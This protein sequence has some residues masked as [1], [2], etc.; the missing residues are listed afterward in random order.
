MRSSILHSLLLMA[1]SI[2]APQ[3]F[4]QFSD[5]FNDGDYINNPTWTGTTDN[6]IVNVTSELQLND[7]APVI[8]QSSLQTEN[9][10]SSLAD[11]EWR[12]RVKQTFSGSDANQSRI[13]IVAN[14]PVTGY[15]GN[16][17]AGVQGYFMKLGEG[18]S[19]DVV[20]FYKDD[21][22]T[23]T[24]LGSCTTLIANSFNIQ[25]K[26]LRGASGDWSIGIDPTAGENFVEEATFT[27]NTYN[28]SAYYGIVCTY[29]S[30]N[31][32]K[33]FFD[34]IYVGNPI[35]DLDPP[36]LV[37]ALATSENTVDVLFNEPVQLS[38][39]QQTSNYT[40]SGFSS[41]NSATR[42]AS[43][44]A[45]VHLVFGSSFTLNQQYTLSVNN[46]ADIAGNAMTAPGSTTFQW[47]SVAAP[48]FRDV[49]FSEILADPTPVVGLPDA[50]FVELY[51]SHAVNTFDLSGWV[52]VNTTTEK[53]LPSYI[54]PPGGY[55]I[56]CD[57]NNVALFQE[58]GPVIGISSFTALTNAT[59]SLTLK[60]SDGQIIDVV[61]YSDAWFA[62]SVKRE[63]GWSLELINPTIP[64][65][66]SVNWSESND[67][68]GGTPDAVNSV[69]NLTPD[70]TAPVALSVTVLSPTQLFVQFSEPVDTT[71][72]SNPFWNI[73]PFNSTNGALW[74]TTLSAVT[75][76]TQSPLSPPNTYQLIVNG[77]SDCSGNMMVNTTLSFTLGFAPQ[78]GEL[79]INELMPDPDP[80]IG[81]PSGEYV[82]I[83]NNSS[84]LID[85]S[86]VQLNSGEF[87]SQVF[88]QPNGFLIVIDDS[89]I[90]AFAGIPN[91]A[92]MPSFPGLTNSGLTLE[93]KTS[94]DVQL[95]II[96]Y[97]LTWYQDNTKSDGGWSL[98]RI[99]PFAPCS[100]KF[101]WRASISNTG[102]T[103]GAENSVFSTEPTASPFVLNSGFL[104][105]EQLYIRFSKSMDVNTVA[106]MNPSLQP[107]NS[108][109]N[110]VWNIDKD[111]VTFS[112]ASSAITET[113]YQL[114]IT[115]L[116]DCEGDQATPELL[117]FV[118]GIQPEFGDIII[119][120][121]LADGT[122]TDQTASP[123]FDFI[124][125]FNRTSTIIELT[126]VTVNTGY[127]DRQVILYPDSFIVVTNAANDPAAFSAFPNT[128]YMVSFPSLTEDG[129]A[130]TLSNP[131]GVLDR[132]TYNKNF[133]QDP[134]KEDGGWSMELINPLDPCSAADNWSGCL[135]PSGTTAGRRNSVHNISP[136]T[137]APVLQYILGEPFLAITLVFNEPLDLESISGLSWIVNGEEIADFNPIL[138]GTENN[139]LI[140][141]YGAMTPGVTYGFELFGITDCWDNVASIITGKFGY[142]Q[143]PQEGDLI[144]NEILYNPKDNGYDFIE[145]YNRSPRIL[146]LSQWK[147]ADATNTIMNTPK[148][149]FDVNYL[150][151]PGEILAITKESS[152]MASIYPGT[153]VE[154]LWELKTL[155]DY[156]SI[157][158]VF[159]VMPTGEI[160]DHIAYDEDMQYPLLNSFDGVS[161]ERI[162]YTRPTS[163]RT[164][165]HSASEKVNFAT[166][167]YLNSQSEL[168]MGN[169]EV[170]SI[171]PEIFSPDNDGNNDVVT[172]HYKM[173]EAGF[174]GDIRIYDSEGRFVRHLMK[175]E[176]LGAT[177]SISWDGFTEDRQKASIGIYVIFFEAFTTTGNTVKAKK[178]CV[179]A[180]TLR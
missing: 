130:I 48:S 90:D 15:T 108:V 131:A 147:L 82:E 77:L 53:I 100:G 91:V 122:T 14:G 135:S 105:E 137:K 133:Y 12:I 6:F 71:D 111:L 107:F 20:R 56:L 25:I 24:L 88:I 97:D 44:F 79:I 126:E 65:Q 37:S 143:A 168:S 99:N 129:M 45:L 104:S 3:I 166:P 26:V 121:I 51:N 22:V 80:V 38:S 102:G 165:W 5:D 17:S 74:S 171:A 7:I 52:F 84:N 62:S 50:E 21:G 173:N 67:P 98:E 118:I 76:T 54:L 163:D 32:T 101:N 70:T 155:P 92:V 75:L 41:P 106:D 145:I 66:S 113:F 136:D 72:F 120:E 83:R 59:D 55:V 85:V 63:G 86:S 154:R 159:L 10:M 141:S 49:L 139:M 180:S 150:L 149:L 36:Q 167:G 39:S 23:T 94:D 132:V 68:N 1:F 58:Y 57:A 29:T 31:A 134:G 4:A 146:S 119:N 69:F 124:E 148:L 35:V 157:D 11:K 161:L 40:V 160:S 60:Y 61:V 179:L 156:S 127:F 27:D 73:L 142:A 140:M 177:G 46:I 174:T 151:L 128:A 114:D 158:E 43:N 115:G 93:M 9:A 18:L 123:K 2:F 152:T 8:T 34:D 112:L 153:R 87:T 16:N 164:N 144:I 109:L 47:V 138:T 116:K 19:L 110:P 125:I 81:M 13:Y 162:S 30:S 103:V 170:L 117:D 28:T 175:S 78:P 64:C 178:T 95:D 176:L 42:D 89:S 169:D 33:F 172:F 96:N